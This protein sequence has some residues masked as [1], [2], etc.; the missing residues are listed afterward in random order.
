MSENEEPKVDAGSSNEG[1]NTPE[2]Q[3]VSMEHFKNLQSTYDKQLGEK[4]KQLDTL[5][6]QVASLSSELEQAKAEMPKDQQE[7]L[8][9]QRD[10]TAKEASVARAQSELNQRALDIRARELLNEHK[11][12]LTVG[13]LVKLGSETDMELAVL[14]KKTEPPK[15][16]LNV[17]K[18]EQVPTGS[19]PS[20]GG[21]VSG[22]DALRAVIDKAKGVRK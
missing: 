17:P 1:E 16:P 12:D 11:V 10:I 20:P 9:R 15:S 19:T 13:D 21:P 2:P 7:M 6:S 5:S 18:T 8:K 4:Q 22:D 3:T 14:R